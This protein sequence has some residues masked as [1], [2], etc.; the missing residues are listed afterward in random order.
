MAWVWQTGKRGDAGYETAR[1]LAD[2]L[3]LHRQHLHLGEVVVKCHHVG[4]NGFLI[5]VFC[6][7]IC[8]GERMLSGPNW[9]PEMSGSGVCL[10]VSH[11]EIS[12]I[13]IK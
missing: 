13:G 6:E 1:Y 12:T 9:K 11:V 2:T 8:K 7:D 4:N 5:R 10:P 3:A